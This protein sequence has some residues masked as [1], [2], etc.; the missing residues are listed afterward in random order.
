MQFARKLLTRIRI[1]INWMASGFDVLIVLNG[2]TEA[3][4]WKQLSQ[5][6]GR[7]QWKW[8]QD[9]VTM[10]IL[11]HET[12]NDAC[13]YFKNRRAEINNVLLILLSRLEIPII[14]FGR[15]F[16]AFY[17]ILFHFIWVIV[18]HCIILESFI[19]HRNVCA[20]SFAR[21]IHYLVNLALI[22]QKTPVCC[23]GYTIFTIE[24]NIYGPGDFPL[25][26]LN[27]QHFLAINIK[28]SHI[29]FLEIIE[30]DQFCIHNRIYVFS[31]TWWLKK[32]G[33]VIDVRNIIFP[34]IDS[35]PLPPNSI[36]WLLFFQ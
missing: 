7:F 2:F 18:F 10:G 3:W 27:W 21:N 17:F 19:F 23:H 11:D 29:F 14:F 9:T 26:S 13:L 30:I 4:I 6:N 34:R 36:L 35:A 33:D 24:M 5:Q 20:W 32:R 12:Q 1:V 28:I 15:L 16:I 25:F 31:F 22:Q 8:L